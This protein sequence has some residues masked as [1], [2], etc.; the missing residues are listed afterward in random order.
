MLRV[1]VNGLVNGQMRI[2]A[3]LH[4]KSW[5]GLEAVTE[6]L[7]KSLEWGG[8]EGIISDGVVAITFQMTDLTSQM[9]RE[10]MTEGLAAMLLTTH[11]LSAIQRQTA[12]APAAGR[13]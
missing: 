4:E 10:T 11:E 8:R 5:K 6:H 2:D 1:M 9:S 12:A 13:R 7:R 3:S